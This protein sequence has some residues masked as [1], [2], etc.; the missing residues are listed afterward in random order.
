MIAAVAGTISPTLQVLQIRSMPISEDEL[1]LLMIAAPIAFTCCALISPL[2]WLLVLGIQAASPFSGRTW[3]PPTPRS[4]LLDLRN[5]LP[6]ADLAVRMAYA[7]AFG[8]IAGSLATFFWFPPLLSL[9]LVGLGLPFLGCA[10]GWQLGVR[11]SR[12]AFKHKQPTH[13][14]EG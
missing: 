11:W 10:A 7:G 12:R 9:Y 8:Y 13:E 6:F 1:R 3:W 5:P 4:N 2:Q 14:H